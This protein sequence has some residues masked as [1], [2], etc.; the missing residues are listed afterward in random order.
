MPDIATDHLRNVVLLSHSGAGKSVLAE[1]MLHAAGVTSRL[2]TTEDGTTVSDY[3]PEET[4]RQT[5]VQTSILPCPWRGHKINVIDTPGYADFRGEVTSGARVADGAVIVVAASA[6][7]EVGTLQMWRLAEERKLPRL[8]YISKIDRENADFQRVMDSI[9]EGLG[10]QCVAVNLPIGAESSFSGIINLLDPNAETPEGLQDLVEAARERLIEAVAD[11]D[12]DLATKYLEGEPL[13][14]EE[15]VQGLRD[16][17]ASG[18][19]VPVLVGASPSEIGTTELMD[20]V[21]DF[22]PSPAQAAAATGTNPSSG[23]D[24]TLSCDSGGPMAALVF[25]NTADPFVGKLSYVR[26]YNGTFKSDS[27]AWNANAEEAERI[28]QVFVVSGKSQEAVTELAAGDIGAVAKLSS[29]MTGQTLCVRESPVTLPGMEFPAPVYQMA[30]FPKSKADVDKMTSSLARISEEDPSLVVS[31]QPDTLEVLLGGL[32]DM[33]VDVAV[34]KMKRKFGVEIQLE[35]PRVPYKET[36]GTVTKVEYKH[37]KQSG[38]HGQYGHV[39]LELEPL[40]RGSG[41]EFAQKV[42]G[43][44][45]PREY[46][47][48]VEKGAGRS[49]QEGVLAG[50]PIVDLRA[51]LVDGS[52]HSVDSS[53]VAFEIAGSHALLDGVQQAGPVLLEPVMRA[54]IIVPDEFTGDVIGELNSKRGRIQGMIPQGDGTTTIDVEVPQAEM[55]RYATE[56]RSQT[57][58]QG[59]FTMEFD[60]YDDVPQHLTAKVVEETKQR[61]EAKA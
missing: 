27:Q 61:D 11:T 35:I 36:I 15:L 55:L 49:L 2:G 37:K 50:F 24:I 59:T 1:S 14:Q 22:M 17:I 31:R 43:G 29:V 44:S 12:D 51:T 57:Q 46:I 30:A 8:V 42:V 4:R 19:I 5:S 53:G 13:T 48:S 40:E 58:G 20:A 21:V 25:K 38:G 60:H 7:V 10:R 28:G 6:G 26:V 41:F 16:G 3:E 45:V 9:I 18:D 33:H 54:E 52:Y 34:E 23:D 47:G 39:V 32:G 56:L